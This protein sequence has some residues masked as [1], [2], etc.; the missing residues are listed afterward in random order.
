MRWPFIDRPLTGVAQ[1]THV[2][3]QLGHQRFQLV[4]TAA[5][6]INGPVQRVDQVF[7]F[8]QLDFDIDEAVFGTHGGS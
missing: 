1:R 8:A 3:G 5:L 7:L 6:F 4:D 2:F